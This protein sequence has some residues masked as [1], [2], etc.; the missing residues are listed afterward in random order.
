M[1]FDCE[2]SKK[3][4]ATRKCKGKSTTTRFEPY[5]STAENAT[6][7]PIEMDHGLADVPVINSQL[8]LSQDAVDHT[9]EGRPDFDFTPIPLPHSDFTTN[10][11]PDVQMQSPN[12]LDSPDEVMKSPDRHSPPSHEPDDQSFTAGNASTSSLNGVKTSNSPKT[13]SKGIKASN[14]KGK[15]KRKINIDTIDENQ[16]TLDGFIKKSSGYKIQNS[17]PTVADNNKKVESTG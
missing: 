10:T 2:S 14:P 6:V 13:Q 1:K 17:E 15:G 11:S 12:L 3:S 5:P 7:H 4:S 16:T 8:Q 9:T